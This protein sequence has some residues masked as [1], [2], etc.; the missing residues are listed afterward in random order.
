MQA[1]VYYA[2]GRRKSAVASLWL[3]PGDPSCK[4]NGIEFKTYMERQLLSNHVQTPLEVTGTIGKVGFNC[5][6]LGG[7]K[8]GQ[9]GAVRLALARALTKMDETLRKPEPLLVINTISAVSD[10]GAMRNTLPS[11]PPPE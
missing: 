1:Q 9:A 11:L 6:A 5:K 7:G 10:P 8:K 4:I 2:T 3:T